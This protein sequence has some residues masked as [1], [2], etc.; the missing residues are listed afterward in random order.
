M[1]DDDLDRCLVCSE[2]V[3]PATGWVEVLQPYRY[4]MATWQQVPSPYSGSWHFSCIS[5][6]RHRDAFM[7]QI[8]ALVTQE[9]LSITYSGPDG[10]SDF[11]APGWAYSETLT[12]GDGFTLYQRPELRSIM[13]VEDCGKFYALGQAALGPAVQEGAFRTF[14]GVDAIRLPESTDGYAGIADW[15][16][17]ELLDSLGITQ[18]YQE[19]LDIGE[20]QY[21]FYDFSNGILD[22]SLTT[23]ITPPSGAIGFLRGRPDL[24]RLCTPDW[25]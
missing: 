9:A 4:V 10:S 2:F 14:S 3:L 16:L 17:T 12:D 22:Y 7:E 6:W 11:Q 20:P 1:M 15:S 19:M 21:K 5:N 24:D 23:R 18:R 8:R 13:L 25:A